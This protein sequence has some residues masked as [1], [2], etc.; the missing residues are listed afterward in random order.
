MA[1]TP[2]GATE[3]AWDCDG[4]RLAGLSWGEAGAAPVLALH[5]WLDN[6]ASFARLAPALAERH[7]VVAPD[8]TGHGQSDRRSADA[9]YNVYDDLPQ[10]HALVRQLGWERFALLGHSRGAIISALYAACFGEQV[11]HLILLD[12]VAPPPLR[13]S[14]FVEQMRNFVTD[15]ERLLSRPNRIFRSVADAITVREEQGLDRRSADLIARRNLKPCEGGFTWSTDP[16]LRGAS[17]AKMTRAQ[18]DAMLAALPR[19]TLL[20]MAERGL[21][22]TAPGR[23]GTLAGRSP[24]LI[25]EEVPGGHHF[26]MQEGVDTLAARITRFLDED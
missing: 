18:V 9:T 16:R 4:L 3:V 19:K 25:L 12:G 15:R 2:E 20:L 6:A 26:H 5:G 24:D 13:E 14:A 11:S 21:A 10:L 22:A 8:L 23:F 1:L 7:Y 17:A